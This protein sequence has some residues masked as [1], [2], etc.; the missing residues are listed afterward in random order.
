MGG[1]G[2]VGYRR[3]TWAIGVFLLILPFA[4][5]GALSLQRG[6]EQARRDEAIDLLRGELGLTRSDVVLRIDDRTAGF[7]RDIYY[8]VQLDPPDLRR[9]VRPPQ[10]RGRPRLAAAPRMAVARPGKRPAHRL[11]RT[12]HAAVPGRPSRVRPALVTSRGR[13]GASTAP[14]HERTLERGRTKRTSNVVR[15]V[16]D[17]ERGSYRK[18]R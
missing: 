10:H 4:A 2:T 17:R 3:A 18:R 7:R 9:L 1:A 12:C 13:G 5:W 6:R 14:A 15:R 11:R 16:R 8:E